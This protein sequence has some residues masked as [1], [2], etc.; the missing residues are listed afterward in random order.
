MSP[1]RLT[2]PDA[3]ISFSAS[4]SLVMRVMRRPSGVRSK[5]DDA[6]DKTCWCSRSRRSFIARWP[7]ICVR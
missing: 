7:T 2:S 1:R 5:N 4:T 3:N 6:S